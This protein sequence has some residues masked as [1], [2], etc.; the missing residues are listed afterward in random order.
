MAPRASLDEKLAGSA[1]GHSHPSRRPRHA[2]SDHVAGLATLKELTGTKVYALRGD[3]D[4]ITSGG[5]GQYLY[6]DSRW[7]P[8]PVDRVLE[9]VDEVKLGGVT[10]LA[11]RTPG[12]THGCTTWTWKVE[13][14]GRTYDVV[15]IGSPNVNP[16][17]RLIGNKDYPEIAADFATTFKVL[18]ALPCDVFLGA[19]G[20]YYGTVEKH[21]RAAKNPT[22]NPFID[23]EGYRA[24]V[25]QNRE[26]LPRHPGRAAGGERTR[27]RPMTSAL[28]AR[29]FR[30]RGGDFAQFGGLVEW[31]RA[32]P[33]TRVRREGAIDGSHNVAR[34]VRPGAVP[35]T[36]RPRRRA[37]LDPTATPQ[38]VQQAAERAIGYLQAESAAW[39]ETR[40]CAACHHGPLP[41]WTLGEAARKGYAVD[42][43]HV[44]DTVE[45]LLGSK[46]K[47]M[48]SK[49]FPDSAAPPDP[50]PQGRG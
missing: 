24:Y 32:S 3:D 49:I 6:T 40:K 36:N 10:L 44:S 42:E 28:R 35:R 2:H 39:L 29:G 31:I 8:C 34:G 14:G 13:D 48:A 30:P 15:V 4:V 22:R 47:L 9:D 23:P 43:E 7:E 38:Q 45:S 16:G 27:R 1:G 46:D 26:G 25:A 11:R 5:K 41:P 37:G 17:Y 19:H 18:K 50:R 20:G 33:P 12:H 21:A